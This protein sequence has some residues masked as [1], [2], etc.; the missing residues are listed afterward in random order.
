MTPLAVLAAADD[1]D[2]ETKKSQVCEANFYA[3]ALALGQGWKNEAKHLFGLA[4]ADCP[5]EFVEYA[6]AIAE[7]KALGAGR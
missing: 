6:G 4:A 1:P 7:L 3:G 2:A 5:K